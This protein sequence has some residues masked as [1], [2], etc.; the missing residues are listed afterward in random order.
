MTNDKG[1]MANDE[2]R[3]T[4]GRYDLA[5]R[6]ARFGESMIVFARRVPPDDFRGHLL[7]QL[8]R[9]ATSVGA[10]Y[11]E[12][13]EAESRKDFRHKIALCRKEAKESR[14]WIRMAVSSQPGLADPARPLVQEAEELTR[15]FSAIVRSVDRNSSP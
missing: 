10:N 12:A 8:L 14:F 1:Q 15:I 9:S 7:D 2:F 13:N 11:C 3:K 6:T 4:D 5:E